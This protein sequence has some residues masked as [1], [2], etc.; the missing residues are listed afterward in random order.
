MMSTGDSESEMGAVLVKNA[1]RMMLSANPTQGGIE[2]SFADGR[3]GLIPFAVI[4]EIGELSNLAHVELPNPSVMVVRSH[5]GES[6]ELPWDFARHY[7]DPSYRPRVEAIAEAG[8]RSIGDRVRQLRKAANM[9]QAE[10]ATATGLG[11][12]TLVRI[13]RGEQSPR[14]GTLVALAGALDLPIAGLLASE[15]IY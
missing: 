13:E 4:P 9:T 15:P 14:Y 8:T 1:E 6:I 5:R 11:R 12:V 10:L 3:G 7:C 2:L